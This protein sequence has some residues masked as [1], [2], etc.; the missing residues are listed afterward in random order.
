MLYR[1]FLFI[2]MTLY[3]VGFVYLNLTG[4]YSLADER[5][6]A[7]LAAYLT[8]V[9]AF[10]AAGVFLSFALPFQPHAGLTGLVN[11]RIVGRVDRLANLFGGI[12]C[13][14]CLIYLVDGG[15]DKIMALGSN[16][17]AYSFR[18]IGLSDRPLY[19][20]A[21]MELSR[22]L[23]LP[24]CLL[25]KLTLRR[26]N[27]ETPQWPLFVMALVF[28]VVSV[29][30][31][32]RGPILLFFVLIAFHLYSSTT[33]VFRYVLYALIF[34]PILGLTGAFFTF[35][36]YNDLD[37]GWSDVLERVDGILINRI[38]LSPVRMTQGWV[39]DN[40]GAYDPPLML[41]YSRISVLWG[42]AY[43][44]S[45]STYSYY[46]APVGVIG[47]LYRNLGQGGIAIF[48]FVLGMA[49]LFVQRRIAQSIDL[50]RTPL[51]F[52]A[53]IL[54]MYIYYGNI[55]SLGPSVILTFL[56][57]APPVAT[58]LVGKASGQPSPKNDGAERPI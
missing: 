15:F 3:A 12:A 24:F 7:H 16:I 18:F 1:Y 34:V 32:D 43:V 56:I 41:A 6:V 49:F 52:V 29:I 47:D 58:V 9:T 51:N 35:L 40:L 44:G 4:V 55:F 36:Q 14:F 45:H 50:I 11:K 2:S 27:V 53:L 26:L 21:P 23:I 25:I 39:F 13:A 42:G 5:V 54:A 22:R 8:F 57:F 31:L 48:G 38:I 10:A 37:F 33:S 30:N 19:L 28:F 17:D 20:S 46:V